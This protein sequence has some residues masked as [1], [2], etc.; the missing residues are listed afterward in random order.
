MI[1]VIIFGNRAWWLYI[2]V[3]GYAVFALATTASGLKNMLGGMAGAGGEP[4]AQ[5]N[6]QKKMEKRGGQ[7]VAYQR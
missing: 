4:E 7:R 2:V 3:P 5:S 1:L 6:R